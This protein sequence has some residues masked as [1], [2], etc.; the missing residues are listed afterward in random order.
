[1]IEEVVTSILDAED[2]AKAMVAAAE[3]NATQVVVDAE[4][5]AESKLKQA[6]EDNKA[7]QVAQVSKAEAD[8]SAQASVALAQAKA[9]T[10]EEMTKYVANVDKAV[11]AILERVL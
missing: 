6:S 7:Y 10:D 9:E 8:A 5:L 2:K 3:E 11:S 1:M 4:K